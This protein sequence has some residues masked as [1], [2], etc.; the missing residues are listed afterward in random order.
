MN[1]TFRTLTQR[2]LSL[3]VKER[4]KCPREIKMRD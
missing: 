1:K 4:A 2:V 3:R